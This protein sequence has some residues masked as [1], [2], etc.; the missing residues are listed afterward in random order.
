MEGMIVGAGHA[1]DIPVELVSRIAGMAGSHGFLG[2]T[3]PASWFMTH[4]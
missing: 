2:D 1:G 3:I 4:E